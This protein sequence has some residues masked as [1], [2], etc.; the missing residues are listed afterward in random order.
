MAGSRASTV[1]AYLAELPHDRRQAL[2]VVREVIVANLPAGFEEGMEYG[3]ISYH[4]PLARYPDTYN[5]KPLGLAALANQKSYMTM[6]L[7]G[8]Y[9]D[10]AEAAWFRKQWTGSGRRLDM[11]KSCVR[12]RSL[13]GVPLDVVAEAI[14]RT[15]VDDFLAAYERSRS[16]ATG[17]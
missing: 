13:E 8:V 4:V 14:S 12:F 10:E 17:G 3:M 1:D 16:R 6:Y 15:S 7:M 11:G 9:S 5:G 2:A